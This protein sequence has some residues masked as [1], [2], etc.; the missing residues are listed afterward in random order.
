MKIIKLFL[1]LLIQSPISYFY[2]HNP[3]NPIYFIIYQF[4]ITLFIF[5]L[6]NAVSLNFN[7][8]TFL[9]HNFQELLKKLLKVIPEKED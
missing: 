4:L 6:D 3:T 1:M 7:N 5:M 8:I 2:Y 9:N